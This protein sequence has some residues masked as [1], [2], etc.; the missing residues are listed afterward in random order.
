M[1]SNYQVLL[2]VKLIA[3]AFICLWG[4]FCVFYPKVND[5]IL[6]KILFGLLGFSAF[7]VCV[8]DKVSFVD[9]TRAEVIMNLFV[10]LVGIRH[11]WMKCIWGHLKAMC[12]RW[13]I[14]VRL[15]NELIPNSGLKNEKNN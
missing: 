12:T 15:R 11:M 10:A 8:S 7:A 5:G 3:A 6:G 13:A 14:C 2:Q 1:I 4:W 9:S